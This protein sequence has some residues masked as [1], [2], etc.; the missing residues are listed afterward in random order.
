MNHINRF[1]DRLRQAEGRQQR[2][3]VLT[4]NEARDLHSDI[5][6]LLLNLETARQHAQVKSEESQ[7]IQVSGGT[8]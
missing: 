3:L 7:E 2:D 8:F 1:I 4:M 6:R 5:T